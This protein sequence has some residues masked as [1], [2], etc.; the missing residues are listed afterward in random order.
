MDVCSRFF[1]LG[2]DW[3]AFLLCGFFVCSVF[4][5]LWQRLFIFISSDVM[6]DIIDVPTCVCLALD[7]LCVDTIMMLA[8]DLW[9]NLWHVYSKWYWLWW[10]N[11]SESNCDCHPLPRSVAGCT[12]L[13]VW[14]TLTS[15]GGTLQQCLVFHCLPSAVNVEYSLHLSFFYSN[16]M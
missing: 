15:S 10:L 12:V 3:L 11:K 4:F 8:C 13:F 5:R 6:C 9:G 7:F 1:A 14:F 2:T 16:L